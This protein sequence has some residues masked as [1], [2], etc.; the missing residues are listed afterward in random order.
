MVDL[1]VGECYYHKH[2]YQ[3]FKLVATDGEMAWLKSETHYIT[4]FV[5]ELEKEKTKLPLP[6]NGVKDD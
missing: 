6:N 5:D 1:K 4:T 3:H 2:M